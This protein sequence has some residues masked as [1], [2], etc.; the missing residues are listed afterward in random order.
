LKTES[1]FP[2][3]LSNYLLFQKQFVHSHTFV[4][5]HETM[6]KEDI[7]KIIAFLLAL[8]FRADSLF[9][10][11]V[12]E[13]PE[14]RY[15][16]N[17][18]SDHISFG[19]QE[20]GWLLAQ[21]K[22]AIAGP[23][24][25]KTGSQYSIVNPDGPVTWGTSNPNIATINS[26]GVL[27]VTGKGVLDITATINGT[28]LTTRIAVGTP[29]FVLANVVHKPGY[30][31]IK[32]NCID[33]EPGYADFI[34]DVR[35]LVVY[36][37]GV[38]NEN[39]PIEWFDSESPEV[40]LDTT[41]DNDNTTIYL[42]VRDMHGNESAPVFVKITG[43]DI[44]DLIIKSWIVNNKGEVFTSTG[45]KVV[46]NSA[47]M[48]ILKR[49]TS[50]EYANARWNPT[51]AVIVNDEGNQRGILWF[52]KGYI[53]HIFPPEELER[54]KTFPN[55]QV[56]VYRVML[57]NFDKQVIQKTPFTVVYKANYPNP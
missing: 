12:D 9:A 56:L 24:L 3:K 30:Y 36:Q 34:R 44:Y 50:G 2:L 4:Q 22:Y 38:K 39:G 17:K 55:N 47:T 51:A 48:P 19:G 26:A 49:N 41:E 8:A 37:W 10:H 53:K 43:Y 27:T 29:R 6:K 18:P 33:T 25:G 31:T 14:I 42:K 32:A 54:I 23:K 28:T 20:A 7:T 46:Y 52:P 40:K 57:L 11:G 13:N 21:L 16:L 45:T 15:Y 5:T 1:R 35:N